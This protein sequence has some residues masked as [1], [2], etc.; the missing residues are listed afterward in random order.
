[1]K[2][3]IPIMMKIASLKSPGIKIHGESTRSKAT[4]RLI[5]SGDIGT[6]IPEIKEETTHLSG[7]SLSFSFYDYHKFSPNMILVKDEK[8]SHFLGCSS[9]GFFVHFGKLSSNRHLP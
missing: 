1:M 3:R 9:N 2:R 6:S 7:V 5:P 8:L 4:N